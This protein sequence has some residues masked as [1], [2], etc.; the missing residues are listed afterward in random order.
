MAITQR[1]IGEK[2]GVSQQLVAL[3]LKGHPRVAEATRK[4]IIRAAQELGYTRYGKGYSKSSG[5]PQSVTQKQIGERL[6]VSQQLVALAL[7]DSPHVS[8]E[9]RRKITQ[10]AQELGYHRYSN[11]HARVL[12]ARRHGKRATTGILAV[13]LE[14][15]HPEA[16]AIAVPFFR[17]C[18]HGIEFEAGRRELGILSIPAHS[19]KVPM[20]I[21]EGWVDGVICLG[22]HQNLFGLENLDLPVVTVACSF[23]T[24][25]G[26][27]PDVEDGIREL[28]K[29][30]IDL[31]HKRIAYIGPG[32]STP[33]SQRLKAYRR[34]LK[35]NS[36]TIDE[37]LIVQHAPYESTLARGEAFEELLARDRQQQVKKGTAPSRLPSFTA[38]V[39]Y[40]DPM[41]IDT[42]RKAQQLGI[43]VPEE[44]SITGFDD[45]SP[46]Y[47]F[48]PTVTS[49]R[50]PLMEMGRR[51]VE[52]VCGN[53]PDANHHHSDALLN[54]SS[55]PRVD[56]VTKLEVFQVE[57]VIHESTAKARA[58]DNF[59]RSGM[60][61][62][63]NSISH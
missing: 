44:L 28:V 39:C 17:E 5:H 21:D 10:A 48:H 18:L 38:V 62:A 22:V 31:G 45:V 11:R 2:L 37:S 34:M 4:R 42:I 32:L 26:L 47:A 58:I 60:S 13:V 46:Q 15:T 49:V 43:K 25:H 24:V 29:H 6:G 51:A 12:I 57:L 23:P 14:P 3:A 9:T 53:V 33:S 7:G 30:L 59:E 41:A 61:G 27:L 36:L 8:N 40:N 50:I 19:E 54:D 56:S 52:F 1:D 16:P 63:F 55:A 35:E 20:L